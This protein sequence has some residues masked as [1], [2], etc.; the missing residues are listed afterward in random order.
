MTTRNNC[1]NAAFSRECPRSVDELRARLYQGEL[2][3]LQATPESLA[4]VDAAQSE[5]DEVF[6]DVG[7]ARSAHLHLG[8]DEYFEKA[9]MLRRKIY[10]GPRFHILIANLLSALGFADS[11]TGV[12]PARLRVVLPGGHENP[13]AAAM[14]YGHRDTWYANPQA[15]LTWWIPLHD[16]DA[17]NS[18]CFF[19]E[20]FDK[21]MKNDS[22][23]FNFQRW[24]EQDE[25]KLIGWQDKNTGLTARYPQLLEEPTGTQIPVKC[26]RGEILLFSGQHLHRTYQHNCELTR[27]S[28]DFRT[29]DFVDQER[30]KEA[31]NTDNRS[32]GAW[33][34]KFLALQDH[35]L[36][37]E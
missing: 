25:K 32:T 35:R 31:I 19:P 18:F 37:P 5:I 24:V 15:M 8:K 14:Y 3:I 34:K 36:M 9:G 29:V 13:A 26:G 27:F 30:G 11:R 2:F 12:D 20:H 10:K 17:S 16:V 6:R 33:N 28:L 21:P 1:R 22:E 4:F 23:V 7:N